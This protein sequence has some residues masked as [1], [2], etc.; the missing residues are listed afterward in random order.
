MFPLKV[1]LIQP[2]H[3]DCIQTLFSIYN[4]EEGIGFKPPIGLLYIATAIK[5]MTVH[6]VKILDCQLE[7]IHH[8]NILDFVKESYDVIGIN[9]W[10]DF[11]YQ[12]LEIARKL[13]AH[14]PT[15]HMVIGGPHVNIF[16]RE[17]LG[18]DFIDSIVMGDGEIPMVNLLS[19]ITDKEVRDKEI[20]GVY[21]CGHKNTDYVPYVH[22]DLDSLPI[23]DRT[24]L[25][26]ER[27]SSVLSSNKAVT[28]MITSRGCPFKC[29]Y[30]KLDF[31]KPVFRSA[32]NVSREFE[33]IRDLGIREVEVYDDT[34]N[35]NQQRTKDICREIINKN[36]KLKWAIRDRVSKAN[37]D[38]LVDLKK[39]GCYRIHYGIESGSNEVLKIC[40][41]I[42]TTDQ[43]RFAV[44]LAKKHGFIILAYFMYG[45]PGETLEEAYKTLDFS[46]ELD[47]DY[48]EYSIAIPYPGTEMYNNALAEGII[49]T[50]YWSEFVMNPKPS[51][52]IPFVIE[53]LISKEE[54]IELRD[55]SIKKF[56][57]RPRYILREIAKVRSW[58]EFSQKFN[59]SIGLL[60]ILRG[61]LV[62]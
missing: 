1:L 14:Y 53:N 39:A 18:F 6:D 13:K 5:E 22:H 24:L 60:N 28:S 50:D 12:T 54:L 10:T 8:E 17:V 42:I 7:D 2:S 9:A 29:V 15:T 16:P 38:I 34:F 19:R 35:W 30:C 27:Y 21:F 33:I 26:I 11:W 62:R 57:F 61:R 59:M 37:E 20:P 55:I 49:P 46:L 31:Q 41:K 4:T 32:E 52:T 44:K 23:P 43:S 48:S 56:Y 51:F 25:P 58:K 47:P 45:L 3:R 40:K 36:L